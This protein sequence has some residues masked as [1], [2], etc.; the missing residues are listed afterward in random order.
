MFF[1]LQRVTF[2][3]LHTYLGVEVE[4]LTS[5]NSGV[6]AVD[7]VILLCT[8]QFL[9]ALYEII[10]C[11][12]LSRFYINYNED[13]KC[14]HSKSRNIQSGLFEGQIS[15]GFYVVRFQVVPTI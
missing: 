9:N 11:A 6:I 8:I 13:L 4:I 7:P 14:D 15:N 5:F 3:A 1:R 2:Y 10:G 12:K